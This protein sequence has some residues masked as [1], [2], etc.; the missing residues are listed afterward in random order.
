MSAATRADVEAVRAQLRRWAHAAERS[1]RTDA[2]ATDW[3]RRLARLA[4]EADARYAAADWDWFWWL[5]EYGSMVSATVREDHQ[6]FEEPLLRA[7]RARQGRAQAAQKARAVHERRAKHTAALI[8]A[9]KRKIRSNRQVRR[10]L[11]G[12]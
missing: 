4:A 1:D 6:R 12:R 5:H 7:L 2:E 9:G 11:K 8:K 3:R 10:V